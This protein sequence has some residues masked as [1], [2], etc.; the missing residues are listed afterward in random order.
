MKHFFEI[1]CYGFVFVTVLIWV[2]APTNDLWEQNTFKRK[3]CRLLNEET[4]FMS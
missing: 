4:L 3:W 1:I 2:N